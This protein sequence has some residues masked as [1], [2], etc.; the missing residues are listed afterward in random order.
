MLQN[1]EACEWLTRALSSLEAPKLDP[2]Y[3]IMRAVCD[4]PFSFW[5]F[6]CFCYLCFVPSFIGLL[7]CCEVKDK[8]PIMKNIQLMNTMDFSSIRKFAGQREAPRT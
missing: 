1:I 7:F 8:Q 3:A 5:L 6:F 2:A 4:L